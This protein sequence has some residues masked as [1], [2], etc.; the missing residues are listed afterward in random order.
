MSALSGKIPAPK[1]IYIAFEAFPRPKG[2]ASHIAAMVT[3][4]ARNYAPVWLLCCGFADMPALQFEGDIIIHRHKLHH[5]NMLQRSRGFGDFIH[6]KL[7]ELPNNPELLIFR[8]PWGGWPALTALPDTPAIFEVNGL[9]SW[10][11]PYTHAAITNNAA[12]HAKIKEIERFCLHNVQGVITVS[13]LTGKALAEKG[14]NPELIHLAPNTASDVFFNPGA[15]N[16]ETELPE[17]G[18]WFG[19][20]GSLHEWQGI[21]VLV[22]AWAGLADEWP[23][24]R[25]LIVHNGKRA[26]LKKLRKRLRKKGLAGRVVLQSPLPHEKLAG[27]ISRM[28]FTCAPLQETF[29]NTVQGCCPVKIVES[30]AAGVPVLA[31]RLK[32]NEALISH[33][34]DGFLVRPGKPR[35][36][37][38]A[39]RRLL[40][41]KGLREKL[42]AGARRTAAERYN[43]D[44]MFNSLDNIFDGLTGRSNLH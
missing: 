8:D 19:Y 39:I 20:F 32:V 29:R 40:K 11:L 7:A 21:D 16:E 37:S 6:D 30:M 33:G 15:D 9:P 31:S 43:R 28:E 2:A 24:V 23:E 14:V 36:W 10:E 12:L 41:D 25:L 44:Y 3:A 34:R 4:L 42:A 27:V 17:G 35:D 22:D 1:S 18:R 26:P 38:L 13:D 5:P